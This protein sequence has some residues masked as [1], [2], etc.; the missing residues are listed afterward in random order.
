VR[1]YS[2][3]SLGQIHFESIGAV[4]PLVLIPMAGR[5]RRMFDDLAELLCKRFRVIA[6]DTPGFGQSDPI[7]SGCTIDDLARGLWEALD[8][9]GVARCHIYGLHSGN[10]IATAMAVQREQRVARLALAGQSHSLIPDQ[11]IR[12]AT[13]VARRGGDAIVSA[14][15]DRLTLGEWAAAFRRISALWHDA[16]IYG[17]GEVE[18]RLGR[19]R[20]RA[21]DELHDPSSSAELYRANFAYDLAGQA[22][23]VAV[24]TLIVEIATPEEDRTIGRQGESLAKRMRN[25]EVAVIEAP[26][27]HSVTL[28]R[29]AEQ[30][31]DILLD[32]FEPV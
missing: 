29:R 4:F 8:E 10:K 6:F 13:I 15:R 9:I 21:V 26:Q 3:T 20:A 31:A 32:F 25:A 16:E 18:P 12:N 2:S 19:I 14:D 5:S 7:P 23:L 28:E 24:R 17:D 1:G 11:R 27:A 30:L 22:A